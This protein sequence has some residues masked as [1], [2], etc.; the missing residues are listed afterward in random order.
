MDRESAYFRLQ[1]TRPETIAYALTD[2]PAGW[3]ADMLDK[4]QK[5][6]DTSARNFQ[7]IYDQDRLLT[8]VMLFGH[9]LRDDPLWPY[10]GFATEPF[11][12][13]PGQRH[14]SVRL[15]FIRR[16][17]SP[18]SFASLRRAIAHGRLSFGE[19]TEVAAI[20]RCWKPPTCSQQTFLPL[21][22]SCRSDRRLWVQ[23]CKLPITKNGIVPPMHA[24]TLDC[25][26]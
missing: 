2:S 14:R 19:S 25:A 22:I 3:A 11:G 21:Q 1:L 23:G 5:C 13:S 12:L 8:E 10:A 9:R 16:S 17:A 6:T 20:S 24:P 4:W 26:N 15:F 7:L 18:T